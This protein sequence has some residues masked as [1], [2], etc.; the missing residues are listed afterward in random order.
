[1]TVKLNRFCSKRKQKMNYPWMLEA[2]KHIGL[3]ENKHAPVITQWVKDLKLS[4][5]TATFR[6]NS[7]AWCFTGDTEIFAKNGWVRLDE[8]K[9][10]HI[11]YQADE[12]GKLSLTPIIRKIE[13]DYSGEV[14]NI[15]H[16]SVKLTCDV[17]HRW[18]G[19]FEHY[20]P[21]SRFGTL[22]ELKDCG[23]TI[24][25]VFSG[26]KDCGLT[27]NQ[28]WLL[29]AFISDGKLRYSQAKDN[30]NKK[31]PTAIE[32]EVSRPRKIKALAAL[33]PQN[34]YTQ[35]RVYGPLTKT[36]LTVFRFKYPDFFKNC[37]SDYKT[38]NDDFINSLSMQDARSFIDAYSIFDGSGIDGAQSTLYTSDENN[39]KNLISILTLAGYFFSIQ[40]NKHSSIYTKKYHIELF[41]A[42]I[43]KI[44]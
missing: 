15:N 11:V 37:I 40:I 17:G 18:W 30:L 38:L 6:P 29:A 16:K 10:D 12:N 5:F 1:M 34:V 44:D 14:F 26:N 20:K 41:L 36:P 25:S 28:L 19:D 43:K 3:D 4:W 21:Q 9:E 27:T 24:R 32:F 8:I 22:D 35:A 13:K 42:E 31:I 23:L 39:L 33:N 2:K 7:V